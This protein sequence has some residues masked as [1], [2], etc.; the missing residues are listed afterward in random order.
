MIEPLRPLLPSIIEVFLCIYGVVVA[1]L[2]VDVRRKGTKNDT[3]TKHLRFS[4]GYFSITIRL[5][6]LRCKSEINQVVYYNLPKF[7]TDRRSLDLRS[8]GE[9]RTW[10]QG[11]PTFYV[12]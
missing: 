1:S 7:Q 5:C 3:P 2:V 10:S 4:I 8:Q 6:M 9:K 12:P 11:G